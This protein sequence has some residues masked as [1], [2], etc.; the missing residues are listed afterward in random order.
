[1]IKG[2]TFDLWDTVFI[3]DSDEPKRKKAGRPTKAVE[4]R[5]LV[6]QFV[7]K[8]QVISQEIV[9]AVYDTQDA[10]FRLAWHEQHVT[11]TVK[12]RLEI[13]LKGLGV[14]LPENELNELVLL[15]EEMELEFRPDFIIGVHDAI[16][17]LSENYKLG[18]ISDAIFS[19]G[20]SLKKLLE[21]EGL[22]KYFTAFVFSDEVGCSKPA[23]CVFE[24]AK[25]GLGFEYNEIIHIGDREHNDVLGPKKMGMHSVLCLAAL[26][27]GSDRTRPDAY[28]ENYNELPK[29]ID[30]IKDN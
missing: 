15:H 5:E 1:M 8:H 30:T 4:R 11:W 12:E 9:N 26:D 22:L 21:D 2:I 6:K 13:V 23:K 10:A 16:K 27:R 17:T 14:T 3:D 7:D 19:P 28:F 18:V 29:L 24:A 25:E 20:R